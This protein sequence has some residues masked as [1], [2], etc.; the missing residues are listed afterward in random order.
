MEG[1]NPLLWWNIAL[2]VLMLLT[3]SL[4][5]YLYRKMKRFQNAHLALET[6]LS[7]GSLDSLLKE[8]VQRVEVME[9]DLNNSKTRLDRTEEKLRAAK[10][11]AAIIRFNA[12]EN[13]GSDLSF[14]LALVNQEGTGLVLSS[15][16]SR[17]ESRVYAKPLLKRESS[18]PLTAEEHQVI[19]K[20]LEGPRI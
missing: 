16:N 19:N 15:F 11:Q 2:V 4:T 9:L 18:Y 8:Y 13:M 1:N 20:A 5:V 14:S 6:F 17:E 10:D 3:L 7:G 12:F